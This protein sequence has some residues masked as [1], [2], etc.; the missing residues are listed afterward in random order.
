MDAK[1][2]LDA[3]A[4]LDPTNDGHWTATG[5][6]AVAA[7]SLL[8]SDANVSRADI[9][10]AAPNWSRTHPSNDPIVPDAGAG[11]AETAN[12]PPATPTP[13]PPINLDVAL[14]TKTARQLPS[15]GRM[16]HVHLPEEFDG[17]NESAGLVVRV[18]EEDGS[19]ALRIFAANGGADAYSST[20]PYIDDVDP[21]IPV[22]NQM[23]WYW[24]PR[25]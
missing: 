21:S 22:E 14:P 12:L 11:P 13:Q 25:V 18:N 6:P 19:V 23:H 9:D 24:P 16:V 17:Q 5:Q 8:V 15:M 1:I 10:A 20:V 2:I 4:S 3:L 7:V